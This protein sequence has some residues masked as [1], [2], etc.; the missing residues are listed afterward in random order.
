LLSGV[1]AVSACSSGRGDEPPVG[2]ST[3]TDTAAA[4]P[5]LE[6]PRWATASSYV[7]RVEAETTVSVQVHLRM[8]DVD[9]ARAE[10]IELSDPKGARY[11]Q[12]LTD[13]E[14]ATK[15]G[16][17]DADVAA[18]RA[19]LENNGLHVTDAPA[20]RAYLTAEGSVSQVEQAFATRLGKYSVK[21]AVLRAPIAAATLPADVAARVGAVLGLATP[22]KARPALVKPIAV[23]PFAPSPA[24][25]TPPA[26]T[27]PTYWAQYMDTT[28]PPF[29]GG[30]ASPSPYGFCNGYVPEQLRE[31]YGFA[32]AVRAGNDGRGQSIA[33]VDA[34][35]SPT[36]L[37]DAQQYATN[38]DPGHPFAAS[39][40]TEQWAPGTPVSNPSDAEGWY[41]EEGLDV[42]AVHA[43]APGANIQFVA[44]QSDNDPDL[45][46]ALNLVVTGRLASVVSNSWAGF[47][48]G[49]DP[50]TFTAYEQVVL[51]GT[52][53]GIGFYFASGDEGD[54]AQNDVAQGYPTGPTVS[55]PSSLPEATAVG[56]T[57]L[58]LGQ[59]NARVFETGWETSISFL[60][61]AGYDGS[62]L[63]YL[64]GNPDPVSS[65]DGGT[66]AQAWWPAAPGGY[67][68]GA[69]GGTSIQ[70]AQPW[71]QVG[72]V[73]GSLAR[74]D[75]KSWRVVPDVGMLADPYTGFQVGETS[76]RSGYSESPIGGTSL[77][78]PL[79]TAAVA[80]AQQASGHRFGLVNPL[81]Y[82]TA[83]LGAFRDVQPQRPR[84]TVAYPG[85]FVATFDYHGPEN[86]N[87]TAPGFDSVTGLGSPNGPQF[88]GALGLLGGL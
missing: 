29:G 81:L 20:N 16:P 28:D 74:V 31:A 82:L 36:L 3:V 87:A 72:T 65:S 10:L 9:G 24:A 56:G 68:F 18:V 79:F 12:F 80:L 42:E 88:L 4:L 77:A 23:A 54:Y 15:Y 40:L 43:L 26:N 66:T 5:G 2:T 30:Y 11:G 35:E 37:Q 34:W 48:Y 27:C 52:L 7:G 46:A 60:L 50:A 84:Q 1:A 45:I 69:G 53:K 59:R 58:A 67:Y 25:S 21:G 38:N 8:Q 19:H 83:Y 57:S 70:Y 62:W 76:G 6:V 47:E 44:A 71:Y 13:A 55:F 22:G 33:I 63:D 39:Q 32:A 64:E 49:E 14:F 78:T 75:H 85:G 73:P 17:S 61:P 51:Q 41:G 86:T